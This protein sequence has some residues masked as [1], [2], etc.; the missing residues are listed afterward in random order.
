MLRTTHL[1]KRALC[2]LCCLALL[3]GAFGC[4]KKEPEPQ[5]SLAFSEPV[6]QD[7]AP[8][9]TNTQPPQD[10][11]AGSAAGEDPLAFNAPQA[12]SAAPGQ[13][14]SVQVL[15]SVAF[16]FPRER[17]LYGGV[18]YQN[19][20]D[21]PISLK[22]ASFTF[23]FSGG[24]QK[25]TFTPVAAEFDVVLPGETA[26]CTLWLPYEKE[27]DLP[28]EASVAAELRAETTDRPAQALQVES[29][30]LVQ[31]Y[32]RFAT[33]SGRLSNPTA[34]EVDLAMVYAAFYDAGDTLL[35][36][37]YFPRN[38]LLQPGEGVAFVSH[39]QS[40]PIPGIAEQTASMRFRAFRI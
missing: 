1:T 25:S 26:Y 38:A 33:L 35:G 20:G 5:D 27:G 36:I 21:A 7:T 18:A 11:G 34:Q 3:P 31:N 2:L 9:D 19:T 32:P 40:L 30:F 8:A 37:W 24:S 28:G 17:M 4:G 22:E 16:V 29:E 13:P 39:L 12:Y 10:T 14:G 23:S 6:P 15:Q